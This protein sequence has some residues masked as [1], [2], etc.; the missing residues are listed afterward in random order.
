MKRWLEWRRRRPDPAR[1][2]L[3]DPLQLG[4]YRTVL[5]IWRAARPR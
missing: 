1:Y 2:D 3:N 5:A 4:A